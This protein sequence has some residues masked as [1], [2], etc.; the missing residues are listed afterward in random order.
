MIHSM[1]YYHLQFAHLL[2]IIPTLVKLNTIYGNAFIIYAL[3]W[4]NQWYP[5]SY[6]YIKD[7]LSQY[8]QFVHL[9]NTIHVLHD[10]AVACPVLKELVVYAMSYILLINYLQ[11]VHLANTVYIYDNT[12]RCTVLKELVVYIMSYIL[13]HKLFTVCT[14][15]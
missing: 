6:I 2:N 10:N 14:L 7:I 9:L 3:C 4:T 12:F 5:L 1:L 13:S 11:L 15:I 8:L